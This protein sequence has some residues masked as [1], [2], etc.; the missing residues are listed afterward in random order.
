MW[1]HTHTHTPPLFAV[2]LV[3]AALQAV[4]E[5]SGVLEVRGHA[6][7]VTLQFCH[8]PPGL[9][10]LDLQRRHLHT[11]T[12]TQSVITL[13]H[14]ICRQRCGARHPASFLPHLGIELLSGLSLRLQFFLRLLQPSADEFDLRLAALQLHGQLA[15][16]AE[17]DAR[18]CD[19]V[20]SAGPE[21]F[22]PADA[23]LSPSFRGVTN[24]VPERTKIIQCL[25]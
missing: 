21:D 8:A 10:Q 19:F 2:H 18:M 6:A 12:H 17:R 4:G 20:L 25:S 13:R 9:L 24:Q 3:H 7:T 1:T 11:H 5:D 22:K 14:L 15:V 16:C 23:H